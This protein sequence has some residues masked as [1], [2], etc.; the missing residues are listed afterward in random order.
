MRQQPSASFSPTT[1]AKDLL[2][3]SQNTPEHVQAVAAVPGHLAESQGPALPELRMRSG[4]A[5]SNT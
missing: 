4:P 5:K 2:F 1:E 3:S